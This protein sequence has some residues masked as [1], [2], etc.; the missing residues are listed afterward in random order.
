[1]RAYLVDDEGQEH[2]VKLGI[3]DWWISDY[4]SYI[5]QRPATLFVE[6]MEDSVLVQLEYSGEQQLVENIPGF[7]R[8]FRIITQRGYAALQERLLATLSKSAEQ[9]YAEFLD[10]HPGF[11]QRLPQ[12]VLA[13]YLGMST[14]YLSQLRNH[15]VAKKPGPSP[16]NGTPATRRPLGD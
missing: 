15:R 14:V 6:A 3:E 13:S 12:Y 9:R 1:M 10:D 7:D 5:Y 8:F 11:A 2:T 16:D 4:S